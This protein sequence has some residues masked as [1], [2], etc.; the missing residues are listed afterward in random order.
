MKHDRGMSVRLRVLALCLFPIFW[1]PAQAQD[2]TS[3]GATQYQLSSGD[4][5]EINVFEE[6]DLNKQ[7][8]IGSSGTISFPLIGSIMAAGMTTEELKQDVTRRL[9]GRYIKDPKVNVV[10]TEYRAFYISGAV[11][12]PGSYP[13][14]PNLTVRKAISIAG[15]L[16]ERASSR[17][18][19]LIKEDDASK[20]LRKMG[21]DDPVGPGDIVQIEEGLF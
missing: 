2:G 12:S 14:Q 16:S 3:T 6:P 1:Q 10:I 13:Y 9:K 21:M 8:K 19:F 20:T 15:G 4:V 11:N 17:K 5:I 18:I 7:V